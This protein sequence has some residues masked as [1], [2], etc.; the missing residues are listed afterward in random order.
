MVKQ[1]ESGR[2]VQTQQLLLNYCFGHFNS[3]VLLLPYSNTVN[4]IN[5]PENGVPNVRL[6]WSESSYRFFDKPLSVLQESSSHLLL[7]LVALRDI[8]EGEEVLLDYGEDWVSAWEKHVKDWEVDMSALTI[9]TS[10]EMN[11]KHTILRTLT[12]QSDYPYPENIFTSCFYSY[13]QRSSTV[14]P[15][16]DSSKGGHQQ[17]VMTDEW[18]YFKGIYETRNL[19]PC[20]ILDRQ[21]SHLKEGEKSSDEIY[22]TVRL[23]NHPGLAENER[24]P[25]GVSYIVTKIPRR[26]VRFSDKLYTTDQHLENAFRHR[27]GLGDLFPDQWMDLSES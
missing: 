7:E 9:T 18:R 6:R 17:Q 16:L 21:E 24:I 3:S 12:E 11:Q 5:H 27:M 19:R 13:S 20:L 25:R 4:L 22:Y 26:A 1:H 8:E 2:L 10:Q 23:M 14:D 15:H